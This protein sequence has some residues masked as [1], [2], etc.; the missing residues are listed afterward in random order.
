MDKNSN[1]DKFLSGWLKARIKPLGEYV[2]P[3]D[4]E[5]FAR[6][7]ERELTDLAKDQGYYADLMEHLRG[8]TV[9][10]YIEN[11]YWKV[12]LLSKDQSI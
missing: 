5:F 1:F 8:Q 3:S 11:Q 9:L 6:E 10:K 2:D 4:K 7:R 12:N